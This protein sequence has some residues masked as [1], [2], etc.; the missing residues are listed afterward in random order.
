MAAG[1]Y[2]ARLPPGTFP[3][4]PSPM[5]TLATLCASAALTLA[6]STPA[7]AQPAN[8]NLEGRETITGPGVY[9][10]STIDATAEAG[11][12]TASCA[13]GG[14]AG[15]SNQSVWWAYTPTENG[16]ISIDTDGS[17]LPGGGFTDTIVSVHT[18]D[19]FPLTEVAC[20]DDDPSNGAGDFTSLID[21]FAVTAGTTYYV[22]VTSYVGGG[23]EN[24]EIQ[25][26]FSGPAAVAVE[27][28]ALPVGY[29][30]EVVGANPFV[31]STRV[32]VTVAEAQAVRVVVY[33]AL[34]RE[35][36][37]LFDGTMGAGA[38][39][40]VAFDRG[41]LSAGTYVVRATGEAFDV[42]QRVTIAR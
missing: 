24:G 22:R 8:D 29:G 26:T 23:R 42:A 17:A 27:P 7:L 6:L 10:S 20:N 16:S 28:A 18:G 15:D 38:P 3:H 30:F 11:E 14:P 41:A 19:A 4:N 12:A 1:L 31:Q 40:E 9:T 34:G 25:M 5:R 37:V 33:D 35:A 21:E 32:A 36:G 2:R 13:F 39:T